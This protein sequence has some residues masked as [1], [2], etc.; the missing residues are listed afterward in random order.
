MRIL[1]THWAPHRL[2]GAPKR[3]SPCLVSATSGSVS[4]R[5]PRS[6]RAAVDEGEWLLV[7]CSDAALATEYACIGEDGHD[8]YLLG[9]ELPGRY[10][11]E[12]SGDAGSDALD[13]SIDADHCHVDQTDVQLVLR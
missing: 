2:P 12:A 5:S 13:I 8:V 10:E 9:F 1:R 11:V 4:L 6:A 7:D 3:R